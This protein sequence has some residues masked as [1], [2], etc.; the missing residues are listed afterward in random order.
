MEKET[1]TIAKQWIERIDNNSAAKMQD[2][3]V[4]E[5]EERGS[6][7][8]IFSDGSSAWEKRRG[9][10]YPGDPYVQ[11]PSCEEWRVDDDEACECGGEEDEADDEQ[12][13]AI[14]KQDGE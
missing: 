6:W 8:Y 4:G 9:D 14:L 5:V 7:V 11:C 13:T 1:V 12:A 10:W 3:A 2:D